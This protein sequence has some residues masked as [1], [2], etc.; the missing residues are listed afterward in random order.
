MG[1]S[2]LTIPSCDDTHFEY[3]YEASKDP[4]VEAINRRECGCDITKEFC[5]S[6]RYWVE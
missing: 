4:P 5:D 1:I 6:E 3:F 2:A